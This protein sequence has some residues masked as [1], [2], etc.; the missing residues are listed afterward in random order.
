MMEESDLGGLSNSYGAS[1]MIPAPPVPPI[2]NEQAS[3][4]SKPTTPKVLPD[5]EAK[6][7]EKADLAIGLG[8]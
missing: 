2:T 1:P 8:R 3:A 6:P 7:A 5:S 4:D